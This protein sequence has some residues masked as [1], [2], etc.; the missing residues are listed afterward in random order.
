MKKRLIKDDEITTK[1]KSNFIPEIDFKKRSWKFDEKQKKIITQCCDERTKIVFLY[2]VAGS[3]KTILAIYSALLA[4]KN[5]IGR[6]ILYVRTITESASKSM[7]ALPGMIQEKL[8]PFIIPLYEKLDELLEPH[9]KT[10]L[11]NSNRITAMP[12]NYMRGAN[13]TNKFVL[14]DEFQNFD[15]KEITTALT[16]IG[17]NTTIICSGDPC[18]SDINGRSAFTDIINIFN[19]EESRENGIFCFEMLESDIHRSEI[20][21]FIV[22]KLGV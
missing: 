16:R 18:Q 21:K 12:I 14:I 17:E 9:S 5:G 13:W 20:L 11:L 4:I 7:G 3:S 10:S 8:D 1:I 19:D 22:K 2:G 15:R 6:D